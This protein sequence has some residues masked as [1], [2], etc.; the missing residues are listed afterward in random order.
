MIPY[1][2]SRND[3]LKAIQQIDAGVLIVPPRQQSAKFCLLF[4]GHHY[5][6]F[7]PKAVLRQANIYAN[8]N[9]L[10]DHYGGSETNSFCTSKGF[11]IVEH[12][13]APH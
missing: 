11:K 5:S 7:P 13:G 10:W 6:H 9:E 12:G 4:D 3:I 8:G 2:I 1:N